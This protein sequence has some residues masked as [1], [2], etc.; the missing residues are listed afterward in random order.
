MV[1]DKRQEFLKKYDEVFDRD[2]N[3]KLCGRYKCSELI[4][5]SDQIEPDVKHGNIDK[6]FMKIESIQNLKSRIGGH[7]ICER[8][9]TGAS[10]VQLDAK[11]GI[12]PYTGC[13]TGISCGMFSPLLAKNITKIS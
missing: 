13:N 4:Y 1:N 5:I 8:C 12:C 7:G 9:G 11:D 3:I 2:G 6:G 10:M